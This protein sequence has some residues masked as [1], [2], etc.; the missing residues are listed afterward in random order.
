MASDLY[1]N[2]PELSGEAQ[3]IAR[4]KKIA[5]MM[6]SRGQ[7]QAPVN[8]MAGNVVVRNSPLEGLGSILQ[9]YLGSKQSQQADKDLVGLADKRQQMVADELSKFEQMRQG[10]PAIEGV[11]PQPERTI[12]SPVAPQAGAQ[13]PSYQTQDE[14]IPAT[15][16]QEGVPAV[17]GNNRQAMIEMISSNFPEVRK[18]AEAMMQLDNRDHQSQQVIAGRDHQSDMQDKRIASSE[19][20]NEVNNDLRAAIANQSEDLTRYGI[21]RRIQA[22][23]KAA[24]LRASSGGR[25]NNPAP[26]MT[27]I[28]DPTDSSRLLRVNARTYTGG[29][30][31]SEG[32]LGVSGKEP[33][34]SKKEEDKGAGQA[35]LSDSITT[36]KDIYQ[37]L[38]END[39][40]SNSKKSTGSNIQ[41]AV[42]S[43][44]VGQ[45]AGRVV[46]TNNQ[47]LRDS[48]NMQRPLLLQAIKAATGMSSKQMDSNSELK[49]WLKAAT[50]T[51]VDVQ[52][53]YDALDSIE[54]K[55][56]SGSTRELEKV[57]SDDGLAAELA[58][59]GL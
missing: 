37:Q 11:A 9:T 38:D 55:Y 12:Q 36:L 47:R 18:R 15:Q 16:G 1:S 19:G 14:V 3:A 53:N 31:G 39:A 35:A 23:L 27:E 52:T 17:Q 7:R 49:L 50:D 28:V 40:I 20:M 45:V 4:R 24:S 41:A 29:G 46:G 43:S 30:L 8:K 48:V 57:P 6:I 32:V 21:D 2:V 5:E 34:A 13:S 51:S 26:S 54:R 59:R 58:K 10:T 25:R 33:T 56:I 22:S 44:G 42:G